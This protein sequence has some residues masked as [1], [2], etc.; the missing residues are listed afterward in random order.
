MS[1]NGHGQALDALTARVA[2]VL[3]AQ[4][5][6]PGALTVRLWRPERGYP[7]GRRWCATIRAPGDQYGTP[8]PTADHTWGATPAAAAAAAWAGFVERLRGETTWRAALV[9]DATAAHERS[10]RG[11]A[12]ALAVSL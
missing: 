1:D 11:L 3:H 6:P 10:A 12:A 4:D 2:H 9:S 7:G 5:L 8:L